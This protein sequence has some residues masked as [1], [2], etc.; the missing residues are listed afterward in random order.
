MVFIFGVLVGIMLTIGLIFLLLFIAKALGF[1]MML[2]NDWRKDHG[3][4]D[5]NYRGY[6]DIDYR[7]YDPG[8]GCRYCF[9]KRW[10]NDRPVEKVDQPEEAEDES[11]DEEGDEEEEVHHEL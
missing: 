6:G 8:Y 1:T 7:R 9:Y 10:Y 4:Y 2:R 11:E 3:Y 5:I